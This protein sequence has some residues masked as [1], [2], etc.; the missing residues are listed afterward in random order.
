[1][2]FEMEQCTDCGSMLPKGLSHHDYCGKGD[3]TQK[4]TQIRLLNE[5][6]RLLNDGL[7]GMCLK[8]DKEIAELKK[9]SVPISKLEELIEYQVRADEGITPTIVIDAS[10]IKHLIKEVK[11]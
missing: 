10:D 6:L 4:H 1:M 2:K 5:K 9:N 8:K 11:G 7:C 3:L